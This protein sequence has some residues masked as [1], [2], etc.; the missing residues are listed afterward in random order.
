[1]TNMNVF[2]PRR[3]SG[4]TLRIFPGSW[5]VLAASSVGCGG[6]CRWDLAAVSGS[7]GA[8]AG[9]WIPI[10]SWI[11]LRAADS[12][13]VQAAADPSS[14]SLANWDNAREGRGCRAWVKWNPR[15]LLR[16]CCPAGGR[17]GCCCSRILFDPCTDPGLGH[18]A[19]DPLLR[20]PHRK[21]S[22]ERPFLWIPAHQTRNCGLI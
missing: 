17:F 4:C 5:T 1:M 13:P 8:G 9:P 14:L 20:E 19:E 18:S 10:P 7:S 2:S 6:S 16:W 12:S 3:N 15:A 22:R 21:D 11:Q